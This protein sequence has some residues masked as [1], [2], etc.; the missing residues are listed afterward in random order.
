MNEKKCIEIDG[1][2]V[3]YK[4]TGPEDG[5]VVIILQGWGT[6]LEVYDSVAACINE[7][8]KVVQLDL[9]GFGKST[10]PREGW[11]V[12]GFADFFVSFMQALDIKKATLLGHSYG[13]RVIIKLAARAELPFEIEKIV[14]V[15]AAGVLPKKTPAQMRKIKRYKILKKIV[16]TKLVDTLFHD[17][18]EAWK[19]RQGSADYRAAS[20][21]MRECLVKAVNEDLTELFPHIKQEVLLIWGENDTATPLSDAKLMEERMPDAGLAAIAN[22]GHFSFLDQPVIFRNIMRSYFLK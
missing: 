11:N 9:P 10:E 17:Q 8:Y 12:D 20:P 7:K 19:K 2:K 6:T 1:Y 18:A 13:G 5:S 22:A 21:R 15:D 4:V 16:N 14:L 3:W